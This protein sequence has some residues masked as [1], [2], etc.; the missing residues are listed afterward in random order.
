MKKYIVAL[1]VSVLTISSFAQTINK[2][3]P[4]KDKKRDYFFYEGS[5]PVN[6][7]QILSIFDF[8][9]TY[10]L[11]LYDKDLNQ[12]AVKEITKKVEGRYN[13]MMYLTNNFLFLKQVVNKKDFIIQVTLNK[14]L[15][16]EK[17]ELKNGSFSTLHFNSAET[18]YYYELSDGKGSFNK[19]DYKSKETLEYKIKLSEEEKVNIKKFN[20]FDNNNYVAILRKRSIKNN[21]HY[22][23]AIHDAEGGEVSKLDRLENNILKSTV[24]F[25]SNKDEI[26]C[27]GNYKE[28]PKNDEISLYDEHAKNPAYSGIYIKSLNTNKLLE[29]YYKYADFTNFNKQ[30]IAD[31]KIK[32]LPKFMFNSEGVV[33]TKNEKIVFGTIE[34]NTY[35]RNDKGGKDYDGPQLDYLLIFGI[36]DLGAI[37]WDQAISLDWDDHTKNRQEDVS[38]KLNDFPK[39]LNISQEGDVIKCHYLFRDKINYFEIKEGQLINKRETNLVKKENNS[40]EIRYQYKKS[41]FWYD[42]FYFNQDGVGESLLLDKIEFDK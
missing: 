22:E 10:E 35:E 25:E 6:K 23:I 38:C 34:Q 36:N 21:K 1:I 5:F 15:S 24:F 20:L 30:M 19:V 27:L 42:N 41:F 32:D 3:F 9:K 39:T 17:F 40:S 33:F 4:Y 8:D 11:H 26:Y 2:I 13:T 12:I 28:M 37:I 16:F 29:Q 14:E 18:S 7:N 31:K